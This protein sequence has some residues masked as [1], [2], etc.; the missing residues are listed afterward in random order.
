MKAQQQPDVDAEQ[1]PAADA[2][3]VEDVEGDYEEAEDPKDAENAVDAEEK[4]NNYI[5]KKMTPADL[6]CRL[7]RSRPAFQGEACFCFSSQMF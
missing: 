7:L 5:K 4:E 2:E 3:D 6:K 1:P